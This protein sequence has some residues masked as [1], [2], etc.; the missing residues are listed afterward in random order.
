[1]STTI[2]TPEQYAH[3]ERAALTRLAEL[4]LRE[5]VRQAWTVLEPAT[6]YVDGWHIGAICEYLQAVSDG[7]IRKLIVNIPPRHGKSLI[8]SVFWQAWTWITRPHTRWLFSSYSSSLSIRD[9]V[10]ARR[11]IESPWYRE[12][13]GDRF[14]LVDDQ[15]QKIRFENSRTGYR[16]AASVDGSNTGEGGDLIISDDPNN[17]RDAESETVRTATN[18]WWDE[19]MSTRGNDP[20]TVAHIV[21]Q[22]R[23]H[24]RDLSGHLLAKGSG[25]EHL[26]LPSRYEPDHPHLWPRDPRTRSGELLWPE[27]F[28]DDEMRALESSMGPYATAGQLQQRP[29]PRAGG[30]FV[31]DQFGTL[32]TLPPNPIALVRAWDNAAT[33]GGGDYTVGVLL[34]KYQDGRY[35]VVDVVRGQWA[36][37]ERDQVKRQTA[38]QDRAAYG[39]RVRVRD[40]Q[41]P[42]SAGKDSA[43]ASVRNLAG[44]S[45]RI[46]RPTGEKEVRAD[47]YA[48]QQQMGNVWLLEGRWNQAY[49]EELCGFPAWAHDDQVDASADAYNEIERMPPS[50]AS[51]PREWRMAGGGQAQGYDLLGEIKQQ[52]WQ[53]AAKNPPT[54]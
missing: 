18:E 19:V 14:N 39:A 11:L 37:S 30:M 7:Q 38:I 16:I 15:N 48:S 28:G 10:K 2:Y 52:G 22:Q 34:A 21:I 31:R 17:V 41:D 54:S 1:M 33:A 29:A 27:R 13:W 50:L 20:R 43:R 24:D 47:P 9:N 51:Q 36:S 8:V 44:F 49:I 35:V 6:P 40:V 25:Y 26:C 45:V 32:P 12:R 53:R 42:G 5:F 3:L 23:T 4:D 46:E